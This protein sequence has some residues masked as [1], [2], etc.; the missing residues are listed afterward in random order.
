MDAPVLISVILPLA[1]PWEPVYRWKGPGEAPGVG[2][3]I[4]VALMGRSYVGVVSGVGVESSLEP[5]RILDAGEPVPG[6][7]QISESEIRYWRA[8]ADY[9]LCSVG[10]V[11]KCAYPQLKTESEE[12]AAR[13]RQRLEQRRGRLLADL[14]KKHNDSVRARLEAQLH[15]VEQELGG[16][17]KGPEYLPELPLSP[18]DA[19][20]VDAIRDAY[21]AGQTTVLLEDNK[22]ELFLSLAGRSLRSGHSV[23]WLVPTPEDAARSEKAAVAAGLS[24]L[25]YDSSLTAPRRRDC[26]ATLRDSAGAHLVIGTRLSLLLPFSKNLGLILLEQEHDPAYKQESPDPR[27]HAREAAILLAGI[28]GARVL[29]SSPTPSLE[30]RYNAESGRYGRVAPAHHTTPCSLHIIDIPAERRKRGMPGLLS[31]QLI[32]GIRQHGNERVLLLCPTHSA[33]C[34]V[35]AVSEEALGA[36]GAA[37]AARLTIGTWAEYLSGEPDKLRRFDRIALVYADA[38]FFGADDDFR[39]DERACQSLV[40]LL[41]RCRPGAQILLQT[42]RASHPLWKHITAGDSDGYAAMLL[43]ERREAAYPPYTRMLRISLRDNAPKRLAYMAQQ[44]EQTL[45]AAFPPASGL[46]LSGPYAPSEAEDLR[47]LQLTLPR[48][49]GIKEKKRRIATLLRDFAAARH[50]SGG[51]LSIDVDPQ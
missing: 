6:L 20:L 19:A 42:T 49:R 48:D 30:S 22:P 9:Y 39:R 8:L 21:A 2:A 33:Y 15:A 31:R 5:S 25:R 26:A 13:I 40:R 11:Y 44:L 17:V 14:E 27:L 28:F 10:E 38:V 23:L 1:L 7:E 45:S 47:V 34:T 32:D 36:L 3:R 35:E 4:R 46:K 29:L 50:Y 41:E 12:T 51:H 16:P 37:E 24:P 18:S 43:K